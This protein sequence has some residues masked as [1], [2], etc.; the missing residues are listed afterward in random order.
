MSEDSFS[1]QPSQVVDPLEAKVV[2]FRQQPDSK[3]FAALRQELRDAGRGELLAEL[4]AT[5][6]QHERDP[7]RAADAWSEAGE[8]MVVLGETATAIEYLRTALELDPTNDRAAD[9]LLEIVEPND[10]AAA[11]EI[12]EGELTELAKKSNKQL[13]PRRASH[14]RRAAILWNDH[15]G[16]VDRALW[17]WQQAWKLEPQR[18]E[19][20]EAA[21]TLY[22]SLGDDAMVGKLWQAELDVLGQQGDRG[23]KAQIRLELGRLALKKKDLEAAANHLEE[24]QKQDPQSLEI[25]EALAEVYAMPGFREGQTRH[26]AGE[27][28]VALGKQRIATR[29]DATGINYL[30]RAVGVD[31]YARASSAALE[32]ALSGTSQW[33]ELDRILRHRSAVVTEPGERQEVLRRRAALYRNQLPNR[34]GLVEVLS[35]LVAYEQPG[36]KATREL[37]ELLREDEEWE[38]LSHLM[39]AEITALGQNP[40][41]SPDVLVGEILEL[42]TIVREHMGER[43]RAAELLH[44]A[45]G[46]APTHEEALARY[47]DHFRERRDWRGLID[48]YEFALDN[49]REA[50]APAEEII[51]RLEEIAQLAELRLGDIPR[52]V[53]AWQRIAELE[54]GSPKVNEAL[55]RLTSRGK[56]WEQLVSSLEAEV[57]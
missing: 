24:G 3:G 47:V 2:V 38:K 29:D 54:P 30:R 11:V 8:A 1:T 23:R 6:A 22:S 33:D 34:A 50:G 43:D 15:L 48:L 10:P 17:H 46:V 5:W 36:S 18:T 19:A 45:L 13:L 39:E 28:F 4:C 41:T 57:A 35:E 53:E 51:R 37:K 32:D 56:M 9:R 42:A 52:A 55:R 27:L 20:L 40:E 16:R 49:I 25:A 31:P 26:K 14:H 44:Q 12:L 21:R 7:V